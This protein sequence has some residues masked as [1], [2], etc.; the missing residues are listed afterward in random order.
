[1]DVDDFSLD[2]KGGG[3]YSL[4]CLTHRTHGTSLYIYLHEWLI[5]MESSSKPPLPIGSMYGIFTYIWLIFMV[6]V[7]KYTSP[8]G[9]HGFGKY[10]KNMMSRELSST[11]NLL[12][13]CAKW[14]RHFSTFFL[15]YWSDSTPLH[16]VSHF[17]HTVIRT[18]NYE[19]A[20]AH[21]LFGENLYTSQLYVTYLS[22]D[23]PLNQLQHIHCHV[24]NAINLEIT[25]EH[26]FRRFKLNLWGPENPMNPSNFEKKKSQLESVWNI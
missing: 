4:I 18:N 10:S 13:L 14:C 3:W 25:A 9:C 12:R 1:M 15:L 23:P 7:G 8:I 16:V 20:K 6:D 11:T 21:D 19:V 17:L 24:S 5:F 2:L 22:L 26:R